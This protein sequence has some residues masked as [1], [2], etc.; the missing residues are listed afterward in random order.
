MDVRKRPGQS[1]MAVYPGWQRHLPGQQPL[2][3]HV[4]ERHR[5]VGAVNNGVPIQLWSYGSEP[6]TSNGGRLL[7]DR[8][9]WQQCYNSLLR[10]METVWMCQ[11][12]R[13][14]MGNNWTSGRATAPMRRP[15]RSYRLLPRG[16]SIAPSSPGL[17]EPNSG[18]ECQ[19]QREGRASQRQLLRTFR[20]EGRM[21][22]E[23]KTADFASMFLVETE[24]LRPSRSVAMRC[25]PFTTLHLLS[26]SKSHNHQPAGTPIYSYFIETLR[27]MV[28]VAVVTNNGTPIDLW[29]YNGNTNQSWKLTRVE[30]PKRSSGH[31]SYWTFLQ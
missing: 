27:T 12:L 24:I 15:L 23:A 28:D 6:V 2:R 20:T 19:T 8:R 22:L 7:A 29:P 3:G 13:H 1:A 4:V 25:R 17:Q 14:R 11:A 31:N 18:V 9:K 30:V 21:P 5:S 26:G 10:M 16:Q